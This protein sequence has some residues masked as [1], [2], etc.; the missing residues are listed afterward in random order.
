M[1]Y[2][3]D[4]AGRS[5]ALSWSGAPANTAQFAVLAPQF[6]LAEVTLSFAGLGIHEPGV[7]WGTML[8][9]LRDVSILMSHGWMAFPC[10]PITVVFFTFQWVSRRMQYTE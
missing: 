9:G 3:C 7:S 4:G 8:Y 2:T 6:V 10:V 5:P 1:A